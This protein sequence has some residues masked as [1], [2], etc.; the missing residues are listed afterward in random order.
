MTIDVS[1]V[2]LEA[3]LPLRELFRREMNCQIV[4]D[5]LPGRG[6]GDL[7]L[8]RAGGRVAGY[9]FVMGYRGEPRDMIQE[10]YV[11]P[12]LRGSAMP[13]FRRLIEV[14]GARR[15]E[16]QSNDVLLTLML[17][18]FATNITSDRIVFHDGL[19]T[20]LVVPGAVFRATA[21][22]DA[23]RI[24]EHKVEGVGE[25]LLEHDGAIVATGGIATHYNPPYGD[26]YL[27]VDAQSRRRGYGSYLVQELKRACYEMGRVPAARCNATNAASRA[28]LQKA[29]LFPCAR[30]LSGVLASS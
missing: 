22:A 18:D 23:G 9:G 13:M 29:G 14:S 20:G 15:I 5:S 26:L 16:A 10:F 28:T 17:Y 6:F 8:I 11:L 4:H 27:E 12:A 7:F 21:E 25:W 19:T 2:P 24:F 3:V 1:P 30:M